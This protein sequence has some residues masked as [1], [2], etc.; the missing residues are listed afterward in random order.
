MGQVIPC[1]KPISG[2][3]LFCTN[4]NVLVMAYKTL[5][6]MYG[7]Y[8]TIPFHTHPLPTIQ[9]HYR[10]L[11]SWIVPTKATHRAPAICRAGSI[12]SKFPF[13]GLWAHCH[14]LATF[15]F[16]TEPCLFLSVFVSI[17]LCMYIL[18]LLVYFSGSL[19]EKGISLEAMTMSVSLKVLYI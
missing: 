16:F 2:F 18:V 6:D 8:S 9:P 1:L 12:F 10:T 13:H 15:L 4:S 3:H 19:Q 14:Q 5:Y 11:S 7:P 17:C